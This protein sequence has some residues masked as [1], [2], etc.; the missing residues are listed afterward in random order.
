MSCSWVS[1]LVARCKALS[2]GK[3]FICGCWEHVLCVRTHYEWKTFQSP[4][5]QA[6]LYQFCAQQ[7]L[8]ITFITYWLMS[9]SWVSHLVSVCVPVLNNCDMDN[10]TYSVQLSVPF[11]CKMPSFLFLPSW[12]WAT[13]CSKWVL[14]KPALRLKVSRKNSKWVE[15]LQLKS[16]A[17]LMADA[18]FSTP[19]GQVAL[20]LLLLSASLYVSK[21]G[22]YWD[23]LC[24]DVVGWLVVGRWLVGCAMWPNGAS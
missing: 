22:A 16:L 21:R 14:T 11:F 10:A 19:L 18:S 6:E 1:H 7:L 13:L 2:D 12:K 9:C 8:F 4:A 3:C 20:K 17:G 15:I 24:R 5:F 23:R